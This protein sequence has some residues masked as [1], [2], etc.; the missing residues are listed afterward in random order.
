M[1]LAVDVR[2]SQIFGGVFAGVDLKVT[3]RRSSSVRSSSDE[4][5]LFFRAVLRANGIDP[6]AVRNARICRV[7]PGRFS[8][9]KT[10]WMHSCRSC[11]CWACGEP[12]IMAR[13]AF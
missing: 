13:P 4:Y 3:F 7:V 12:L 8:S 5:G 10:F 11:R 6:N 1:L 9:R 2:S